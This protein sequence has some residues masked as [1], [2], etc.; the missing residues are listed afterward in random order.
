M[1]G[2]YK[3][4]VKVAS[5]GQRGKW[6]EAEVQKLLKLKSDADLHFTANRTLDARAAGGRFP[7]QAGDF[8]WYKLSEG[9]SSNGI[10][11]VKEVEH[12]FRLPFKNLDN[13]SYAR[14]YKREL[15]GS[16]VLV[17]VAHRLP[18]MRP[19]EVLWRA[20]P[21]SYFAN[22]NDVKGVGSWDLS[23]VPYAD[24]KAILKGL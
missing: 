21:L 3:K 15:A 22:R 18:N 8:V 9:V 13:D 14:M 11:E 23:A 19:A 1:L 16:Q 24:F 4:P 12:E 17:L 7:A 6:A 5:V 20:L 2:A 10:L